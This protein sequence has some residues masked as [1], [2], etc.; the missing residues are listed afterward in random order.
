MSLGILRLIIMGYIDASDA[1]ELKEN[2]DPDFKIIT[3]N[4][5]VE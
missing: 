4:G 1:V 2:G 5:I 3:L